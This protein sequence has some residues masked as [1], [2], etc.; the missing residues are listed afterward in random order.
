MTLPVYAS[1]VMEEDIHVRNELE[2]IFVKIMP[3][4]H[5]SRKTDTTEPG[6]RIDVII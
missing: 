2:E 1:E 6:T 5:K 3:Y 4:S